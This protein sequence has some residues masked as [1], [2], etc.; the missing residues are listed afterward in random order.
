[1]LRH[2]VRQNSDAHNF[3]GIFVRFEDCQLL[4]II[5]QLSLNSADRLSYICGCAID[6]SA[7]VEN[8]SNPSA[9]L[10]TVRVDLF[11]TTDAGYS[12]F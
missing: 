8:G 6:I 1:M 11:N 4:Y 12:P 5:G 9:T 10:L 3:L 7:G 2:T